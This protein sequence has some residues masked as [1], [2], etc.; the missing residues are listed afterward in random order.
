MISILLAIKNENKNLIYFLNYLKKQSYRNY[1][2]II[3]DNSDNLKSLNYLRNYKGIYNLKF[4]RL[5]KNFHATN[6]RG[7]QIN[8]AFR[9]SKG[10]IIFFPD[11]DMY[12]SVNL[13]SEISNKMN[14]PCRFFVREKIMGNGI[15]SSIR[16]FER[17]FY[18]GS[19]IDAPRVINRSTFHRIRG[20]DQNID[21]GPD[22]WDI[23]KRTKNVK[24]KISKNFVYHNEMNLNFLKTLKKKK[25]YLNSFFLYKKKWTIDDDLKKQLGIKYRFFLVFF[26][27]KKKIKYLFLNFEKYLVLIFFKI[28]LG[29]LYIINKSK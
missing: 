29:F 26:E 2:L 17:F 10:N 1:E 16:N 21:F 15:Y 24:S 8:S 6:K 27:N 11:A 19:V 22:D 18:T 5:K 9:A 23:S 14:G 13:L 4:F 12:L 20:F 25:K 28:V 7:E 3:C